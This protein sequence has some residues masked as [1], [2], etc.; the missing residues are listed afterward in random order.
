[1]VLTKRAFVPIIANKMKNSAIRIYSILA[2]LAALWCIGIVTAPVLKL[3]THDTSADGIYSFYSRICHQDDGRSFHL[4]E[5]KFGV[6]IRCTAIY[7]SFFV[8]MLLMPLFK[9]FRKLLTPL[10]KFLIAAMIPMIVDVL[11]NDIGIHSS[12]TTSRVITGAFLGGTMPW[13]IVPL[14]IEA[15]LQII[16]RK[17]NYPQDSGV[18]NYVRKTK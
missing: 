2:I 1:M 9:S 14:F 17:Q 5:E 15:S 10:P 11:L 13:Y 16:N 12:T 4:G 6:C 18:L 7:F 8:G 3:S